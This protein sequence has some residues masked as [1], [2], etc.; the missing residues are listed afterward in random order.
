MASGVQY[1]RRSAEF[2]LLKARAMHQ[3]EA[4]MEL[5]AFAG[6]M[7]LRVAHMLL[8]SVADKPQQLSIMSQ[9]QKN[10]V[11][12]LGAQVPGNEVRDQAVK[13]A[14]TDDDKIKY[15]KALAE[16][17]DY[18]SLDAL[19][20]SMQALNNTISGINNKDAE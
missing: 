1:G 14:A 2:R 6:G 4:R 12:M 7:G 18:V 19:L 17:D 13:R 9:L 5:L 16:Q 11:S 15:A 10:L 3:Y 20:Q 8:A